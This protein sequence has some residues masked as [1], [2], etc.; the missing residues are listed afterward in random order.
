[1]WKFILMLLGMTCCDCGLLFVEALEK[2][3]GT[4]SK[5]NTLYSNCILLRVI[6]GCFF[7]DKLTS[8]D[9]STTTSKSPCCLLFRPV[10]PN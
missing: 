5:S 1:M 2:L 10:F 8:L 4:L 3:V 6:G 7:Y 9:L